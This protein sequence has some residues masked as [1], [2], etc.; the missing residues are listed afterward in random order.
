VCTAGMDGKAMNDDAASS[1]SPCPNFLHHIYGLVSTL[2]EGDPWIDL[3][4][5]VLMR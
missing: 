5:S 2:Y 4:A 1:T 3:R